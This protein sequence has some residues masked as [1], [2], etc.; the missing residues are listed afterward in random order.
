M[1]FIPVKSDVMPALQRPALRGTVIAATLLALASCG[2]SSSDDTPGAS[3]PPSSPT[4]PAP[5]TATSDNESEQIGGRGTI[6]YSGGATGTV[7]FTSVGC[8]VLDGEFKTVTAPDVN[9]QSATI[10]PSFTSNL[11]GAD[12]T[13]TLQTTDDAYVKNGASGIS[14]SKSAG[15]WIVTISG[16]ELGSANLNDPI[17]INGTLTCGSVTGS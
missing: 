15:T 14:A 10:P 11:A 7:D 2:S 5:T 6:H 16:T 1:A 9:D 8:A 4:D 17:T 12:T 13:A 3:A